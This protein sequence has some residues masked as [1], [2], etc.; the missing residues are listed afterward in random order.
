[1][2]KLNLLV[3]ILLV[4]LLQGCNVL[5]YQMDFKVQQTG[6][7]LEGNVY[8]NGRHLGYAE[9]GL[10]EIDPINMTEGNIQFNGFYEGRPFNYSFSITTTHMESKRLHFTIDE[11]NL[12]T[13]AMH[14]KI[15]ESEEP[16][17]GDVI[18]N[19]KPIGKTI[20]GE[21]ILPT[22][23]LETGRVEL[24]GDYRERE[25]SLNFKVEEGDLSLGQMNFQ[26]NQKDLSNILFD[27]ADLNRLALEED[28]LRG[29]NQERFNAGA[30]LLKMNSLASQ[31]AYE[32]SKDMGE[33]EYFAHKNLGG[34]EVGDRLKAAGVFYTVAAEDL[35]LFENLNK[36][37]NLSVRAV[38]GWMKSPGH[39]SPIVDAD[40]L[41]SD[42]G[43]GVFCKEKSCY[44]TFVFIGN[45][46]ETKTTLPP[47]YLSFY[48]LHDPNFG[49]KFE[50]P[51]GLKVQ[52]TAPINVII[53]KNREQDE[54]LVR[55]EEVDILIKFDNVQELNEKLNAAPEVGVVVEN[56]GNS[57]AAITLGFDYYP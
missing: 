34:K 56:K 53:V 13:F 25:F 18:L 28:I 6:R 38:E 24:R 45:Q 10:I 36:E 42:G 37:T 46:R 27:A 5:N 1:M 41:F 23:E 4:V 3:C 40:H 12:E 57:E 39:R 54:K 50:V 2:V 30:P 15:A 51:V 29:I 52:S 48:Y 49:F 9:D 7:P 16:L 20:N 35:S 32:H 47:Q 17:N 14:F 55:G 44:I 43:A 22:K 19:G 33:N 11:T 31:V 26:V 21:I 8:L